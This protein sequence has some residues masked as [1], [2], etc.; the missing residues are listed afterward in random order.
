M[1]PLAHDALPGE[2]LREL[3]PIVAELSAVLDPDALLPAI[4]RQLRRLLDYEQLEIYRPQ[5]DGVL[6]LA[7]S[8][9]AL[10]GSAGVRIRPGQGIVGAAAA[11]RQ[12]VFAPDVSGDSRY[13]AGRADVVSELALPLVH[14]DRLVGVIN[15]E[16]RDAKAFSRDA[17][18]ALRVLASHV[19]V[20]VDNASLHRE[21]RWYAGLLA[22]LHDIGKETASIL[23]LDE[24]LHRLAEVVKRVIDYD[25]FGILLL[26]PGTDELVLRKSVRYGGEAHKTRIRVSE[27]LTGAAVREKQPILVGDVSA[28]PRYLPLVPGTRSELVVP[29]VHKDRVVGVFD[30]ESPELNRFTDEH[31]KVLMP[32]ASQVAVAIENARLWGEILKRDQRIVK[33]LDL[34]RE[35][36]SG[37][38]PEETPQG[39]GYETCAHFVAARELGGDI[40]EFFEL[41]DDRLAVA[42]GD[43]AGK[44]VPAALYGAFASGTLRARA[45]HLQE[46]G[47]VLFRVNRTMRRRGVEGLF[48]TIAYGLFDFVRR[49]LRLANSGLPY[50]LHCRPGGISCR[51]IELPGLP[52][53][54]FDDATYEVRRI[55]PLEPGD[56][57]VFYSD[58]L[59]EAAHGDEEYGV[60]RLSA[61]VR[62]HAAESAES[63]T[64]AIRT[65]VDRFLAGSTP[66]DDVTLVVVKIR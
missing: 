49:E 8:E 65:D 13:V 64:A 4:A 51:P 32:L 41:G 15:I 66:A 3:L 36:Q 45:F 21:A 63:I 28:D 26:E 31:V 44:G 10:P 29:L 34:A 40:H 50:P 17:V 47:E 20:A 30:L 35:V 57:F 53:G 24:L 58:G 59:V 62:S 22:T 61:L 33:E 11:S 54:L 5:R 39:A 12:A 19:A 27:G 2:L 46:P 56:I 60:E 55:L 48:C 6:V 38:F 1:K 9:G 23:D 18:T 14:Q 52:L 7:H 25:S 43:V 16:G 37:L 42:V